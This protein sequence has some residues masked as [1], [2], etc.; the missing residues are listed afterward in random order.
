MP[1]CATLALIKSARDTLAAATNSHT[2]L[3][4]LMSTDAAASTAEQRLEVA[5]VRSHSPSRLSK[6]NSVSKPRETFPSKLGHSD[7]RLPAQ[8]SR[9][10]GGQVGPAGSRGTIPQL[11]PLLPAFLPCRNTHGHLQNNSSHTVLK[12]ISA[13]R[14]LS[15]RRSVKH[16]QA[17]PPAEREVKPLNS[18]LIYHRGGNTNDCF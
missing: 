15:R 2:A 18:T 6:C 8:S 11:P 7:H 9:L 4:L 12:S 16:L 17:K 1:V 14:V 5:D 13:P 10:P 3:N